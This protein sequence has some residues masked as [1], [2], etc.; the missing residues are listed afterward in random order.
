M[1]CRE[2]KDIKTEEEQPP[3]RQKER[4]A[5]DNLLLG[6]SPYRSQDGSVRLWDADKNVCINTA[7]LNTPLRCT[8]Y[9]PDG[10]FLA[11]GQQDGVLAVLSTSSLHEVSAVLLEGSVPS[12]SSRQGTL[13]VISARGLQEISPSSA[14]SKR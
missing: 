12:Q 14:I 1:L 6:L 13:P 8:A 10:R 5:A 3:K 7:E 4:H 2:R 9:S 11:V